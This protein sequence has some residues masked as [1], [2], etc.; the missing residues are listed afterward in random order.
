MGRLACNYY[1][2]YGSMA[3]YNQHLKSNMGMIE[4]LKVFSLSSEFKHIPIREEEKVELARLMMSVPVPIKGS[5]EDGT[6]KINVLLQ[7]YI[8]RLK[9]DGFALNSDM[10]YVT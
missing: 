9:L 7:A 5:G 4:L 6:T 8:S 3:V 10:I 1:I 2:K